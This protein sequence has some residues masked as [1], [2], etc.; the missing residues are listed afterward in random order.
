MAPTLKINDKY[1]N[2]SQVVKWYL[3]GL[4][5]VVIDSIGDQHAKTYDSAS[6]AAAALAFVNNL[7][8]ID[9]IDGL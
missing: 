1:L 3:D 2:R 6:Q 8:D 5:L 9:D 7:T 4:T